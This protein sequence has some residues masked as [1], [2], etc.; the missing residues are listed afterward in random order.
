MH[1][2]PNCSRFAV[3]VGGL[4]YYIGNKNASERAIPGKPPPCRNIINN[5]LALANDLA[6]YKNKRL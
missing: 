4:F 5:T 1:C 3:L 6:A 2:N